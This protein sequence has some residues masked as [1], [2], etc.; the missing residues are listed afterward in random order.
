MKRFLTLFR[1]SFFRFSLSFSLFF[2]LIKRDHVEKSIERRTHK[3]FSLFFTAQF[4]WQRNFSPLLV[5][6][7][8]MKE[9]A[10]LGGGE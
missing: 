10:P 6:Y 8:L 5:F 3:K 2:I 9:K 4:L 7:G 1:R